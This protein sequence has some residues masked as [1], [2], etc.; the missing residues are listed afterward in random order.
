MP[1]PWT[2]HFAYYASPMKLFEYMASQRAI[3]ASNLPS[4]GEV[5]ADG[6]SGLLYPVGDAKALGAAVARLRDDPALGERL[7]ARAYQEV[8]AHYTWAA[9]ARA[10]L[11]KVLSAE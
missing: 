3:I 1:M 2:E 9:R 7:A 5:L 8:M 4:T 11:K 10:I 6:E